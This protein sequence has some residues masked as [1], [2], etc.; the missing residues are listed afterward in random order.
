M[1]RHQKDCSLRSLRSL[2]KSSEILQIWC[3]AGGN[4]IAGTYPLH[5]A[6]VQKQP[7][8]SICPKLYS[9][10]Y[11]NSRHGVSSGFPWNST[12]RPLPRFFPIFR[13]KECCNARWDEKQEGCWWLPGYSWSWKLKPGWLKTSKSSQIISNPWSILVSPCCSCSRINLGL[14]ENVGYIPNEIAI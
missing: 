10:K 6:V 13:H 1:R 11:P 5:T 12:W 2:P 4:Q 3:I 14:S 8:N 7:F 9:S